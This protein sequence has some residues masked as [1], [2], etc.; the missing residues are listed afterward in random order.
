HRRAQ[1]DSS[2]LRSI[3]LRQAS[4]GEEDE[5]SLT[6][7]NLS[8]EP[9]GWKAR[10]GESDQRREASPAWGGGNPHCEAWTASPK[11]M[12]WSA[13]RPLVGAFAVRIPGATLRHRNGL[14][15]AV[16]PASAEQG[17]RA[18]GVPQEP[19]RSCR[20]LRER[21]AGDTGRTTPGPGGALV[22]RGANRTS[23]RA[24]YRPTKA[25]QCGGTGGRRSERLES[26]VEAGELAP[27][28]PLEGSEASV[29]RLDRGNHAEPIEVP[30][31]VH[32]TGTES[33]GDPSGRA[34]RS[35]E[36]PDAGMRARPGRWE[37]WGATP[38]ATRPNGTSLGANRYWVWTC[39]DRL[40]C[41]SGLLLGVPI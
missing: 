17:D 13:E 15:P 7:R 36:E 28:D 32:G 16:P 22:R 2:T 24:R 31:Q 18:S 21:P 3:R 40:C 11:A 29:G 5:M 34:N 30:P 8:P 12:L 41:S 26:P 37:R 10:P 14:V 20:L 19:G 35:A 33:H 39:E 25:T 23:G 27:E 6:L 38:S 9:C 4:L 1:G